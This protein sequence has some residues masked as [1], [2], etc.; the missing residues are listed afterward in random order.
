MCTQVTEVQGDLEPSSV[1][2]LLYLFLELCGCC[3][4]LGEQKQEAGKLPEGAAEPASAPPSGGPVCQVWRA[5]L[6]VRRG[7]Q[8]VPCVIRPRSVGHLG[9]ERCGWRVRPTAR[10]RGD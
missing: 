7:D 2:K 1:P 4:L 9:S 5:K 3:Q 8:P 10:R 6:F